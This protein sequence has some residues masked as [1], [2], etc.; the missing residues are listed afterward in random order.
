MIFFFRGFI[1]EVGN[2]DL[3]VYIYMFICVFVILFFFFVFSM[4]VYI[5]LY[6][7]IC[8]FFLVL[9]GNSFTGYYLWVYVSIFGF[10]FLIILEI[11]NIQDKCFYY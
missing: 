10:N 2:Y 8:I 4:V 7:S 5:Q 3:Y 6:L 9:L 1:I 11:F